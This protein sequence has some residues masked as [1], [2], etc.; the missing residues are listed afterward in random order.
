MTAVDCAIRAVAPWFGAKRRMAE[1]IVAELGEHDSYVEPFCGSCAV[2]LGKQQV[3]FETV[4]DLHGDLTHLLRCLQ[5]EAVALWLYGQTA[6]TCMAEGLLKDAHELLGGSPPP[7]MGA[8]VDRHRAY[9]Y[10]IQ[11]W[12]MR[13]GVSGT[14]LGEVSGVSSCIATRFTTGGGSPTVR[15]TSMVESIPAWH[16]RL[17]SVVVL[18]RD[19]FALIEQ[20]DDKS[21][22]VIYLDPPYLAGSRTGLD[23]ASGKAA[24][25]HEFEAG[26]VGIFGHVDDHTRLA[27]ALGRFKRARVVVSY[28]AHPRLAELYPGWT[29]RDCTQNKNMS[30]FTGR[31][32]RYS[33]SP[34]V[35]LI[36]GPS[37]T[38]GGS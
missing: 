37:Y 7:D 19:A 3:S 35:L 24:Y 11:S 21:G 22:V 26:G 5:D 31:G 36:N 2:L 27:D 4:N 15:W 13:S 14:K 17:R 30:N 20:I 8:P 10:L 34:E 9:A 33:K 32:E 28:Y 23:R 1:M 12:M 38:G 16:L 29:V 25:L 18:R 6:R